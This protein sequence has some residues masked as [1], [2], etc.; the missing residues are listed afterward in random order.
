MSSPG[1]TVWREETRAGQT[2]PARGRTGAVGEAGRRPDACDG[3]DVKEK[4][5]RVR[6]LLGT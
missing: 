4:S 6:K 1:D 2:W 3:I 5:G